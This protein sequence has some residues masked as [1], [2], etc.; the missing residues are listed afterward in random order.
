MLASDGVE[1]VTHFSVGE[2]FLGKSFGAMERDEPLPYVH[3][4]D[5]VF[6]VLAIEA[7]FPTLTSFLRSYGPKNAR[8]FLQTGQR[9][10]D[11]ST[12]MISYLV[13]QYR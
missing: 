12:Y 2:L 11:A 6:P 13:R 8:H 10:Y 7:A 5:N 1:T 4:L 3:D 9:I